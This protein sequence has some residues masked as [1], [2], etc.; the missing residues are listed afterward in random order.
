M[1]LVALAVS[2]YAVF[3]IGLAALV[4]PRMGAMASTALLVTLWIGSAFLI[5]AMGALGLGL[6]H[7]VPSRMQY[8]DVLRRESDWTDKQ[9]NGLIRS[10]LADRPAYA[11]GV[12][13]IAEIPYATKQIAVQTE[14][15]RRLDE[16]A[17]F[18]RARADAGRTARRLQLLSPSLVL[19]VVLETAAGSDAARHDAFL[20]RAHEYTGALRSFFWPRALKEAAEPTVRACAA[21]PAKMAFL[22]HDGIPK[23]AEDHPVT[24][25]AGRIA[26]L[27][28][29]IWLLAAA[30][31]LL[32]W[33]PRQFDWSD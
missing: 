13:R 21:C 29:Y 22:S 3:W 16:T 10:Y 2:G 33:R 4:A 5:P 24:D 28:V 7:P 20:V 23:F 8:L 15:E 25:V 18:D 26:P 32:A 1:A 11:A 9:R 14:L 31:A 17:R 30:T 12:N 27:V 6:L 19:G